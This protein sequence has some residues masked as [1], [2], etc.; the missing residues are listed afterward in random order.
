MLAAFCALTAAC[1]PV[2]AESQPPARVDRLAFM[3]GCWHRTTASTVVEEQWM[4]P[5]GGIMMGL[6]RTTAGGSV[7][8]YE[9]L[10]VFAAGD[11]LV[12]GSIPSRQ[13]YAEFREKTLTDRE[14]VFEN[15]AHDF[16]Q[17]IGYRSS[18]SDSLI[19]FIE[20]PRN[21]TVRRIEYP[22]SRTTCPAAIR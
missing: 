14:V 21:G 5:R 15:L 17:R 12:Y 16:P 2:C 4:S 6:G 13:S 11:T 19:A 3:A 8:E 22:Y 20:G 10:R 1:L 9:F 7:R 18:G